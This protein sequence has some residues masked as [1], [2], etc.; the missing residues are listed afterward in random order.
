MSGHWRCLFLLPLPSSLLRLDCLQSS[1]SSAHGAMCAGTMGWWSACLRS[2]LNHSIPNGSQL[3]QTHGTSDAIQSAHTL[4]LGTIISPHC[5]PPGLLGGPHS[6]MCHESASGLLLHHWYSLGQGLWHTAWWWITSN[7]N[8][9]QSPLS[10]WQSFPCW[11]CGKPLDADLATARKISNC[12]CRWLHP[13]KVSLTCSRRFVYMNTG[14][15]KA[16]FLLS[17]L[18]VFSVATQ[19]SERA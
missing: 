19:T 4:P 6:A 12:F 5:L 10:R 3:C 8:A 11:G 2:W 17:A 1:A 15:R 9:S 14:R 7:L 16:R 18:N 13:T